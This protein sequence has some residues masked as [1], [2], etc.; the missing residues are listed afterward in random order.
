MFAN[1]PPESYVRNQVKLLQSETLALRVAD[2]LGIQPKSSPEGVVSAAARRWG[3]L[4]QN[5]LSEEQQRIAAIQEAVKVRTTPQSQVI[6]VQYDAPDP[7][8]AA[9]GANTVATEFVALN[10][11]TRWQLVQDTAEW[12]SK[13]T[14]D[15]KIKLESGSRELQDFARSSGLIFAGSQSTLLQDRLRQLQDALTKAETDRATNLA[16]Y[17]AAMSSDTEG[18]PDLLV[19]GPLRQYQTDLQGLRRELADLKAIYTPA[20]Y[21]VVRLEA[22]IASLES[23]IAKERRALLERLRTEYEA[24]AR[25]ERALGEKNTVDLRQAQ[26]LNEKQNRYNLL[27]RE[28]ESTQ[29]L[30][31]SML[32]K[33]KEAGVASALRATNVR[34]LDPARAARAAVLAESPAQR[35]AG[36]RSRRLG[37]RRTGADPRQLRSR[38]EPWR[39]RAAECSR[40]GSDPIRPGRSRIGRYLARPDRPQPSQQQSRA[41]DLAAGRIVAQRVFPNDPGVDPVRF[42]GCAA[43]TATRARPGDH[44]PRARR[45]E[46]HG[47]DQ[48]RHRSGGDRSPRAAH[49]CGSAPANPARIFRHCCRGRAFRP[50]AKPRF[51]RRAGP[52]DDRPGNPSA[53]PVGFAQRTSAWEEFRSCSIRGI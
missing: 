1:A 27:K 25:L 40:T 21:K 15:L 18:L 32:Q 47:S 34:V 38:Q 33:V 2:R 37:R 39:H 6:E 17:E 41:G 36:V 49:R 51:D 7:E 4:G 12:L 28:V 11:E 13:Q 35:G 42:P 24:S 30:Y 23:A 20:H 26:E 45:G 43:R 31:E 14:A 19:T 5:R 22:Q 16:R 3:L 53:E 8:L 48:P 9:V 50:G 46:N 52:P 10:Q 29:Q 44:Q